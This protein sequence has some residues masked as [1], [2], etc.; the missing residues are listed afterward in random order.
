[1]KKSIILKI[2]IIMFMLALINSIGYKVEAATD[3]LFIGNSRTYYNEVDQIFENI[4]KNAGKNVEAERVA[5]GGKSLLQNYA[6][7]DVKTAIKK[8]KW[9]YVILQEAADVALGDLATFKSGA[10]KMTD[11]IKQYN[12]NAKILY[13]AVWVFR[14]MKQ[15][16]QTTTNSNYETVAN[17]TGGSVFYTGNAFINCNK[18]YP[19]IAL[20]RTDNLNDNRHPSPAGSYLSACCTFAKIYNTS[21][22]GIEYYKSGKK[23]LSKTT[24]TNLQ[25]VAAT[26]AGLKTIEVSQ[27]LY[28]R[29]SIVKTNKAKVTILVH[30]AAGINTSK[31]KLYIGTSSSG[32]EI[33]KQLIK[34]S[35]G[36]YT[37]TGARI[38]DT[39]GYTGDKYDY[40]FVVK[41]AQ[42]TTSYKNFYIETCDYSGKC[43]MT[44]DVQLKALSS[45]NSSGE[46]FASNIAPRVDIRRVGDKLLFD[47]NDSTGIKSVTITTVPTNGTATTILSYSGKTSSGYKTSMITSLFTLSKLNAA[48]QS[49][50][51]YKFRIVSEDKAGNTAEKVVIIKIK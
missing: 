36:V 34:S 49:D 50:G 10:K 11:L 27:D 25:K 29:I 19:D 32:T 4:A 45:A 46:Y 7:D 6:Y 8:G 12:P 31:T 51:V 44:Q 26:T 43:Y 15:S 13:N 16:N 37:N 3:V 14:N 18:T 48:K 42:L 1:M 23:T 24:A 22:V 38:V 2:L 28:P 5:Y 17:L 9:E 30:D 33:K 39:T 21:P 47:I 35:N 20:F 40:G 41:K